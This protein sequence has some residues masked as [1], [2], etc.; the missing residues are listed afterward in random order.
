MYCGASEMFLNPGGGDAR[1]ED[2]YWSSFLFGMGSG[3]W[4]ILIIFSV[5]WSVIRVVIFSR[6]FYIYLLCWCKTD[7]NFTVLEISIFWNAFSALK[8]LESR[9]LVGNSVNGEMIMTNWNLSQVKTSL[10]VLSIFNQL[11]VYDAKNVKK[12]SKNKTT[13]IFCVL[14]PPQSMCQ[15]GHCTYCTLTQEKTENWVLQLK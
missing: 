10:R 8:I 4:L 13:L 12:S 11:I 9:S 2:S 5:F 3:L 14:M 15:I 6:W 1:G 7:P